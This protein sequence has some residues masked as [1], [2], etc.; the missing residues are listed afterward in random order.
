V[1]DLMDQLTIIYLTWDDRTNL[2]K[3]LNYIADNN[4]IDSFSFSIRDI[5]LALSANMTYYFQIEEFSTLIS[6]NE[7]YREII[8]ESMYNDLEYYQELQININN[9]WSNSI[10]YYIDQTFNLN[11]I[12]D[13]NELINAI[14]ERKKTAKK[15]NEALLLDS[16]PVVED[17]TFDYDLRLKKN[18]LRNAEKESTIKSFDSDVSGINETLEVNRWFNSDDNFEP[19]EVPF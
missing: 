18:L 1:I 3:I 19:S 16:S 14:A 15:I 10:N 6:R 7:L 9:S 4:L 8:E 13:K 12:L 2:I 17:Y 11:S 5:L